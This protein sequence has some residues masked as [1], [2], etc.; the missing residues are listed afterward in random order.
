[1]AFAFGE[2][3]LKTERLLDTFFLICPLGFEPLVL[4]ELKGLQSWLIGSDMRPSSDPFNILEV[5]K[6]GIEIQTT[7]HVGFQLNHFVKSCVRI[8]WRWKSKKISHVSELKTWLRGLRPL[9][10]TK[11][12]IRLQISSRKS[13]LQ[14]EKMILR[15]FQ[16]DWKNL[17]EVEGQALFVDVYDDQFTLSWDLSGDPLYKRGLTEFKGVAPLRENLAHLL[18]QELTEGATGPE[19]Q[20]SI[21][22]DPMMGSGTFLWESLGWNQANHARKFSFENFVSVPGF[23]KTEW[24]KNLKR[25]TQSLFGEHLGLDQSFDMIKIAQQNCLSFPNAK[26]KLVQNDLLKPS[27]SFESSQNVYLISNP[28]F[29]ERISVKS[30]QELINQSLKQFSPTKAL[31]LV[32]RASMLDCENYHLVST[33]EFLHGGLE[34]KSL[35]FSRS[36]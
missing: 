23:L 2:L 13:R 1:V 32:P 3:K 20:D 9:E 31:F 35:V 21:L 27:H 6:G 18:L 34:V 11:S 10:I 26:V 28:P 7:T 5:R 8:L 36:R 16:E 14:N 24:W 12:P 4:Q 25:P 19:L 17:T 29:G 33:R 15:V 22:V 30:I